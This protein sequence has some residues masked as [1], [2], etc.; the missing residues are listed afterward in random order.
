LRGS[1]VFGDGCVVFFG[2]VNAESD[3]CDVVHLAAP[4]TTRREVWDDM[5]AAGQ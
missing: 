3:T 4:G 1:D 5:L 2:D